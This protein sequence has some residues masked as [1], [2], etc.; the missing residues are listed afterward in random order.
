M[1]NKGYKFEN[2]RIDLLLWY[3]DQ[4]ATRP[5]REYTFEFFEE[6]TLAGIITHK[7]SPTFRDI[8]VPKV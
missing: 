3:K 8:G 5:T 7:T 6:T 1:Y 2:R 4:Q